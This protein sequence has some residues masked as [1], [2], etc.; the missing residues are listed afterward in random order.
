MKNKTNKNY[1]DIVKWLESLRYE[2]NTIGST[3]SKSYDTS[4]SM[5]VRK[6]YNDLDFNS[7]IYD[8]FNISTDNHSVLNIA[9]DCIYCD[10]NYQ[11]V[12]FW[13]YAF[14]Y[15]NCF[16]EIVFVPIIDVK[17]TLKMCLGAI[18]DM[19]LF[20][21]FQYRY[22]RRF[23]SLSDFDKTGKLI[24]KEFLKRSDAIDEALYCY[25]K[26]YN[27]TD[28][29][30]EVY[31]KMSVSDRKKNCLTIYR[32]KNIYKNVVDN[33]HNVSYKINLIS[34]SIMIFLNSLDCSGI[35]DVDI[36]KYCTKNGDGLFTSKP[37]FI[38]IPSCTYY[39]KYFPVYINVRDISCLTPSDMS[40]TKHLS[41]FIVQT[42]KDKVNNFSLKY[43]STNIFPG[44]VLSDYNKC[45]IYLLYIMLLFGKNKVIPVTLGNIS[46]KLAADVLMNYFN[47]T[48]K[49]EFLTKYRGS[50]TVSLGKIF[51]SEKRKYWNKKEIQ[52]INTDADLLLNYST[53]AYYGGINSS[54]DIGY[55]TDKT[56]DYDLKNAYPTAM[57]MIPDIDWNGKVIEKEIHDQYL[58]LNE[59]NAP[60]IAFFGYVK[61]VFPKEVDFPCIPVPV[62]GNLVFP[63]S[64]KGLE[65]VYVSGPEIFLALKL[66][67]EIWCKRGFICK[68]LYIDNHISY[69]LRSVL[70]MLVNK[71][72]EAGKLY[73]KKSLFEIILK[74]LS[75]NIYGKASQNV[76]GKRFFDPLSEQM[77][78]GKDSK[79][80]NPVIAALTTSL[81]RSVILATLN[82]IVN[83]GYRV[84]SVTTDGFISDVPMN[85][86]ESLN[87]FGFLDV[88]QCSRLYLTDGTDKSIWERKH[89]QSDL[90]NFTTRGNVSLNIGN[91]EKNIKPGVCAHNGYISGFVKDSYEDRKDLMQKVL[92]R[93]G[94]VLSISESKTSFKEIILK[95]KKLECRKRHTN[96]SMDFD[97]KRK[98]VYSSIKTIYPIIEHET[99]EIANFNTKPFDTIDEYILYLKIKKGKK[100]LR[101]Q[102]HWALFFSSVGIRSLGIK[103][104]C[105]DFE[106]LKLKT[107]VMG[108]RLKKWN[109]PYL[110]SKVKLDDKIAWINQFNKSNRM[111]NKE[112]WKNAGRKKREN[113]MIDDIY[114]QEL[115]TEMIN[116]KDIIKEDKK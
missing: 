110:D 89:E 66:G 108:H 38:G 88:F 112:N 58:T 5:Y 8:F 84:F 94:K 1:V 114:V 47:C 72:N 60:N 56:F 53:N 113:E 70:K 35:Y 49:D 107:C 95:E 22:T 73:G 4:F 100:V 48:K 67:A 46:E 85:I 78:D 68:R 44:F 33:P 31:K 54:I 42:L 13:Q 2:K 83:K 40:D 71:R 12:L 80:T 28:I 115:L 79:I 25:D 101:T 10:D 57:C 96:L 29:T 75:N 43:N 69:S 86:L 34:N 37:K 87:L 41:K 52:A 30:A 20:D 93:N 105:Q 109:I 21:K 91:P 77:I 45:N 99:F 76:K 81:V 19:L 98:P 63:L 104:R 27:P 3:K 7:S 90:L 24:E 111:F 92:S 18:Y 39:W 32:K 62:D 61:F 16:Y 116:Y 15:E 64:S 9:C 51:D 106:W 50:K 55:Y 97:M 23:Y 65:G 82:Q 103:K 36:L 17:P 59:I 102:E 26:D 11:S 14:F 74:V 6:T